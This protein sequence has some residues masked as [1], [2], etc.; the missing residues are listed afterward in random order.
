M[1]KKLLKMKKGVIFVFEN[2]DAKMGSMII[3]KCGYEE[4]VTL[5]LPVPILVNIFPRRALGT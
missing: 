4:G 1:H 3:T 5:S 2:E